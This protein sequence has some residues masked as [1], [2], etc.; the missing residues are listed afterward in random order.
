[1]SV[2]LGFVHSH[3]ITERIIHCKLQRKPLA[4][5]PAGRLSASNQAR[6]GGIRLTVKALDMTDESRR[7]G[8]AIAP[9]R[10]QCQAAE[11]GDAIYR[12]SGKRPGEGCPPGPE[13]R[14]IVSVSLAAASV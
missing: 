13:A 5:G 7:Y 1:V 12:L 10:R 11:C 4:D 2:T 6:R 3:H 8:E 14:V 9:G